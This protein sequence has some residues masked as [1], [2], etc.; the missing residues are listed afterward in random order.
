MPLVDALKIVDSAISLWKEMKD[1]AGKSL[2]RTS[3]QVFG[4]LQKTWDNTT[5]LSGSFI[6][7]P[8]PVPSISLSSNVSPLIQDHLRI[9][10]NPLTR[11]SS[12]RY[13]RKFGSDRF[14][15]LTLPSFDA[16]DVSGRP[17]Q[18]ATAAGAEKLKKEMLAWLTK[19]G[20]LDLMNRI[21]KPFYV[22]EVKRQAQGKKRGKETR[23]QIIFF[24]V[25]GVG[26][27]ELRSDGGLYANESFEGRGE[28]TPEQLLRWQIPLEKE[29]GTTVPKIWSRVELGFSKSVPTATFKKWQIHEVEDKVSPTGEVM[30]DGCSVCSPEVMRRV[31][32]ALELSSLPSA[33]Q[34]RVGGAKGVWFLDPE[35]DLASTDLRISVTPS[36]RK[37]QWHDEDEYN[38]DTAR[39]TL[40]VLAYAK[41]PKEA[42]LNLQLVPILEHG[43][44]SYETFKSIL[45]DHLEREIKELEEARKDPL[46]LRRWVEKEGGGATATDSN[47]SG[48][49]FMGGMPASDQQRL[50]MLIDAGFELDRCETMRKA[51]D[52]IVAQ[53]WDSLIADFKVRVPKSTNLMCIADPTGS[54]EE[55]ECWL[56]F[57]K[58]PIDE[59]TGIRED[60]IVGEILVARNPAHLASDIQRVTAVDFK[61]KYTKLR[62]LKDVIVYSTKGDRPLASFLSGGDYDGDKC[63]ICW[64]Q[65]LVTPFKNT[66]PLTKSQEIKLT[67]Y[68]SKSDTKLAKYLDYDQKHPNTLLPLLLENGLERMLFNDSYLGRVTN[69]HCWLAYKSGDITSPSAV[70]IAQVASFLVDAPK[71]GLLF[72]K[73]IIEKQKID[74]PRYKQPLTTD[75]L[76]W[77][78]TS[79]DHVL[80]RLRF[81]TALPHIRAR[82]EQLAA[83]AAAAIVK[84]GSYM[85]ELCNLSRHLESRRQR[86]PQLNRIFSNLHRKLEAMATEWHRFNAVR[87]DLDASAG[88]SAS[89]SF[90]GKAGVEE[91]KESATFRRVIDSLRQQFLDYKPDASASPSFISHSTSLGLGGSSPPPLSA[92]ECELYQLW[93]SEAGEY[94]WRLVKAS[95]AYGAQSWRGKEL[96]WWVVGEELCALKGAERRCRVVRNEVHVGLRV[97]KGWVGREEEG[98]EMEVEF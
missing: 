42:M 60:R 72:K 5:Q 98:E 14:L 71:Q 25:R 48:V 22:K 50:I 59:K 11:V 88:S 38:G 43:G 82:K 78:P 30:D 52:K 41:P 64:D 96:V 39:L 86:S 51:L 26:I 80:D 97:G 49:D 68:F 6:I 40:D 54:L 10:L 85:P 3:D 46:L 58:G 67:D 45:E 55:G 47:G 20:E 15:H 23:F 91:V 19:D 63:W 95:V 77:T 1:F 92:S 73:E 56:Q 28:M 62:N 17:A 36:M 27:G 90:R 84:N 16:S 13:L 29:A 2:E 44:V 69:L 61:D 31:M 89:R 7:S 53:F 66:P 75:L 9:K 70:K 18:Y 8:K 87:Y 93:S 24:A 12:N 57:S 79:K 35:M 65:R 4:S 83:E 81:S 34:G 94:M 32:A 37:Y 21:W 76:T 33:V 74:T